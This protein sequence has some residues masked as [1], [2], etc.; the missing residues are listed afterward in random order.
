MQQETIDLKTLLKV[1]YV[2]PERGFE[3]SPDGKQAAFAW[4]PNG[5]WEIYELPL[6]QSAPPKQITHGPGGKFSP[7]YDPTGDRIAYVLDLD[8]GERFDIYIYDRLKD[9]HHN[10]TPATPETIQPN[11]SWSP[12]GSQIAYISDRRGQFETY[13][14]PASGGLPQL[15]LA[16]PHPGWIVRW[17]PDG[18]WLLII[19]ETHGQDY[20]TFIVPSVGG[21]PRQISAGSD[22]INAK[23]SRWSP[24]STQIAFSSDLHGFYDVGLYSLE[25]GQIK[26][27]TSGEGEKEAPYWSPDGR[28]LAYVIYRGP[29]SWLALQDL[30]ADSPTTY[31]VEPGVHYSPRF[32]PDGKHLVFVFDN[33]HHPDDLWQLNLGDGSL[34]QLTNSLPTELEEAA[35]VKPHEVHYPSLDGTPVPALLFKSGGTDQ[36]SP[37]IIMIHGGPTWLFQYLWYPL[38]QH[39]ASRGWVVLAPNYRGSTGYGKTWQQANRFDL[40][41]VDT[42]DVVAGVD[43]LVQ[44]GL[45]DPGQV[46]V[47]GRSHGGYLTMTCLTQYPDRWAAGSAVVPFLNWFTSHAN[48]RE[49]LQ[50]WDIQNFGDPEENRQLWHDRSPYFFLDRIQSP[51]QLICGANDPRCPA[52]ESLAAKEK[53]LEL[54]KQVD[55]MLYPDEGH[56]FLKID[57]LVD[58]EVR[59]VDF[60][61]QALE[62]KEGS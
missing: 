30:E 32:T 57:N 3:I 5:Q 16:L 18:Q 14:I 22:A 39:M 24:D 23:D 26:W 10:L 47:S 49:D 33:Y 25:N 19:A 40:G 53:L 43:Y 17:S 36:P 56:A 2:D 20:G 45:S 51:V 50:H 21:K 46:A 31:Q 27:L 52:S 41:G 54:G 44:T 7:C 60:L 34:H 28:Q 12:D 55:F 38:F 48:S 35:F 6:D 4:N 9:Q 59:R 58:S 11:L 62:E 61:A 8:G 13:V 29:D 15:V 37:G 1:P 42:K